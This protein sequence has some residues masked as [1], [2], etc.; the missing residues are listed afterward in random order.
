MELQDPCMSF[1]CRDIGLDCMYEVTGTTKSDIMR[2]FISH[3]ELSHGMPVLPAELL[4]RIQETLSN[5]KE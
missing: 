2:E 3:A 1:C 4:L 5:G